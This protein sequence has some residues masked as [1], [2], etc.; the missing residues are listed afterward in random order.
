MGPKTQSFMWSNIKNKEEPLLPSEWAQHVFSMNVGAKDAFWRLE[1][2]ALISRNPESEFRDF[3][4]MKLD[5]VK[6]RDFICG[7]NVSE[8]R[9]IEQC[10]EV[11]SAASA[12]L[13]SD[14]PDSRD[15]CT[16][17]TN[18]SKLENLLE[19]PVNIQNFERNLL[20]GPVT[21]QNLASKV[22]S[23]K[24]YLTHYLVNISV[25]KE[26]LNVLQKYQSDEFD[27]KS[28]E[29]EVK[30]FLTCM[31]KYIY[32]DVYSSTEYLINRDSKLYSM[33]RMN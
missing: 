13:N 6:F 16:L 1:K 2:V 19:G 5:I 18:I 23:M 12:L 26:T 31:R 25:L 29:E 17:E 4:E 9:I 3:L 8:L 32:R 20:D 33:D 27:L 7:F 24:Y 11:I 28:A 22:T 30:K 21:N 14:F 15:R 10:N